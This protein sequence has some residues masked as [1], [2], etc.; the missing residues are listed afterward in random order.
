MLHPTADIDATAAIGEGSQIWH[1]AQ[2]RERA[3]VGADCIIGK[4]V[5]IDHDV[6]VGDRVKIQNGALVYHG[7]TLES[8][9]FVGPGA[10]FTNDV[11]PR[12]ITTAGELASAGAWQVTE[13]TVA[14]GSS[15]GAGAVVVAGSHVGRY[16][17]VGA[18][19]VVTRPVADHALVVGNPARQ[20]GWVCVCGRRLE[21][22]DLPNRGAVGAA[23]ARCPADDA[24]FE[25]V[26][27]VCRRTAAAA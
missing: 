11:Y 1:R 12:S 17:L 21:T 13:T 14:Y 8:G 25:I 16:A 27:G 26:D 3:V 15:V 19:A 5:Y 9:V 10:I 4:D 6:R 7:V 18:G 23:G 2:I 22:E 20:I 24:R